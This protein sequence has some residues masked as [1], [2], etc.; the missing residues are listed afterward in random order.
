[1]LKCQ[2]KTHKTRFQKWSWAIGR[3]LL[4]SLRWI[5]NQSPG[6]RHAGWCHMEQM[7]G[8]FLSINDSRSVKFPLKPLTLV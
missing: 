2:M 5:G 4:T 6:C 3:L 8:L 1:M 7:S